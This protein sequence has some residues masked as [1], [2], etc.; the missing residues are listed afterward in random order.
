MVQTPPPPSSPSSPSPPPLP[1][2]HSPELHQIL[3]KA[4]LLP[5]SSSSSSSNSTP[6]TITSIT[7]LTTCPQTYNTSYKLTLSSN[8][9]YVLKISP[10]PETRVLRYECGILEAEADLL[11]LLQQQATAAGPGPQVPR[12]LSYDDTRSIIDSPYI[13]LSWLPGVSLRTA[14][15]SMSPE[16]IARVEK[17]IGAYLRSLSNISPPAA[18]AAGFG[19]ATRTAKRYTHWRDAFTALVEAVLSDGEEMLVLLPYQEIRQ[20]VRRWTPALDE[21]RC[22][23][24][25]VLDFDDG[26]VLLRDGEEGEG[27]MEVVGVVDFER[28]GW[29]D[30]LLCA[31]CLRPSEAFMEGYGKEALEGAGAKVRRLLYSCYY[32]CVKVVGAYYHETGECN[33]MEERKNLIRSLNELVNLAAE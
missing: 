11:P 9:S 29:Y 1:Q 7:D 17:S 19:R 31:A 8:T 26:G 15:P 20:Q 4:F 12:V 3:S 30:P 32:A 2:P 21:V 13:L 23:G 5:S 25:A 18:A 33:E 27:G 24:L 22:P 28:A 10:P 6:P 16:A 14:R